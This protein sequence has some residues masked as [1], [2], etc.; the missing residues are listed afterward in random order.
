MEFSEIFTALEKTSGVTNLEEAKLKVTDENNY[1]SFGGFK[2]S[3]DENQDGL[4]YDMVYGSFRKAHSLCVSLSIS[5]VFEDFKE[6]I[7]ELEKL[8]IVDNYNMFAIGIKAHTMEQEQD[9]QLHISFNTEFYTPPLTEKIS[10]EL[11]ES[12]FITLRFL[13]NS[14]GSFS[15]FLKAKG[16]VHDYLIEVG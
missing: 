14:P 11:L 10:N 3:S 1:F 8:R 15:E 16:I 13:E 5:F 7:S 2:Y 6:K 9:D 12:I 4:P